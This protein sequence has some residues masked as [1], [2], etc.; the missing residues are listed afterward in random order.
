M[1]NISNLKEASFLKT[2]P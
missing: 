2:S 1:I